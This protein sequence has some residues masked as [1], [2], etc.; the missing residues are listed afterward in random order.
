M[1]KNLLKPIPGEPINPLDYRIMQH[2]ALIEELLCKAEV[3]IKKAREHMATQNIGPVSDSARVAGKVLSTLVA[4]SRAHKEL[5]WV[6]QHPSLR[7]EQSH[8]KTTS[9]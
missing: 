5:S 4:Y 1:S 3:E 9:L 2:V 8:T 7:M 6:K